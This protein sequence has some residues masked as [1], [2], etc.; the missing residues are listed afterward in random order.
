MKMIIPNIYDKLFGNLTLDITDTL[1]QLNFKPQPL[2]LK[3]IDEMVESLKK[4]N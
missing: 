3:G 2:F 1:T 4:E